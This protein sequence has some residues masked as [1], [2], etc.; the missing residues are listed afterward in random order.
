ML[1]CNFDFGEKSTTVSI[2]VIYVHT[3]A[4]SCGDTPVFSFRRSNRFFAILTYWR[5]NDCGGGLEYTLQAYKSC[6]RS[7]TDKLERTDS[8]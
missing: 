5:E 7:R 4:S 1:V 3:G 6:S 8:K 2:L